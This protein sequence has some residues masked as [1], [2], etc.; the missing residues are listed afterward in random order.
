[1]PNKNFKQPFNNININA[2][3]SGSLN[4]IL[5]RLY[6][7]LQNY[8]NSKYAVVILFLV[9][10]SE[11]SFFPIPPDLLLIPMVF[12]IPKKAFYY[13]FITSLA[14]VL[15]GVFGYFIGYLFYQGFL[16]SL[17]VNFGYQEHFNY[18]KNFYSQY[19][20]AA[21]F[22]AG[23]TPIPY[24]IATIASGVFK[25]N[26][27]GFIIM[28]LLSRGLRFFLLAGIAA[29]YQKQGAQIVK[30]HFKIIFLLISVLVFIGAAVYLIYKFYFS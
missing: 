1:M 29:L 14:S 11:S 27:L 6:R 16:E 17:I 24:K 7:W 4:S 2:Q 13:A 3:N 21:I 30:R 23:F 26:L 12:A 28:S 9:A 10:F 20:L 5:Q 8:S 19:G 15:G 22:I 25:A 18:F